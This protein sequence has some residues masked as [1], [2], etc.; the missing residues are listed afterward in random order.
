MKYLKRFERYYLPEDD[1]EPTKEYLDGVI[2]YTNYRYRDLIDFKNDEEV[3]EFILDCEL[4]G[5]GESICA[6]HLMRR[7]DEKH[8]DNIVKTISGTR[9]LK[10]RP[11]VE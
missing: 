9:F 7:F 5:W 11:E 4:D 2:K 3:K 10:T 1:T 6:F 8:G